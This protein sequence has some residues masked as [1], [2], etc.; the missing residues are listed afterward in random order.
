MKISP[1]ELKERLDRGDKFRLIDVREPDEW[2][3]AQLPT[4]E[5]LPMSQFQ[6]H[7]VE[8]LDPGEDIVV[9]CH[10]G[11]RSGRVQDYLKAK[12]FINV[13]NLTGGIDAWA[14][15]VDPAMKRY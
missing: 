11:M 9:Y 13:K 2:A 12:G 15:Q 1:A 6:Q 4:A 14:T 10:H 8:Q 3:I 5:L 7:G